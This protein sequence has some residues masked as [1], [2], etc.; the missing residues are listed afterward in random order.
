M[1]QVTY[2]WNGELENSYFGHIFSEIYKEKIYEPILGGKSNLTIIDLGANVGI[3]A[4]YFSDFGKVYAIEPAQEHYEALTSMI[5][6]NKLEGKIIP[7]K[8]AI[9]MD[10]GE[11]PLGHNENRTMY[12]L[13]TAVWDPK[14][15]TEKVRA[16]NFKTLFEENKIDHVDFMKFDVEGSE[17][18]IV[19]GTAFGEVADKIDAIVIESHQW[20]GR[21]P[22][23]LIEGLKNRGFTVEPIK[24]DATILYAH[25]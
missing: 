18:E 3:T 12:S 11:F 16:I 7:L 19:G 8:V 4:N 14:L 1:K 10:D 24:A 21:H 2:Y 6:A 13:H 25:R 15:G 5:L 9:Y 23:Q 20:S 17:Q 22:H